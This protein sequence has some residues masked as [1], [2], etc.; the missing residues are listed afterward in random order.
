MFNSTNTFRR[1]EIRSQ[2]RDRAIVSIVLLLNIVLSNN[3]L[4]FF[5]DRIIE[6]FD[7]IQFENFDN[8]D[9]FVDFEN[10]DVSIKHVSIFEFLILNVD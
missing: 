9:D 2:I 5:I 8:N 7:D 4:Y 10:V 3:F 6:L 1:R